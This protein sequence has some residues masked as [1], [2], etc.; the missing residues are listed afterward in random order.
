VNIASIA[1][2]VGGR[3]GLSYTVSKHGI[4]GLTK[5]TAFMYADSGVRCNAVCPGGVD[6]NIGASTSVYSDVGMARLGGVLGT[7][8]RTGAPEEV[9]EI[10][11]F[12]TSPAASLMNGAIFTADAG[13]T[14]G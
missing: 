8:V 1:G 12:L 4:I 13:W 10:V 5:N 3:A 14:A 2:L 9:A 6:T 11:H 7:A